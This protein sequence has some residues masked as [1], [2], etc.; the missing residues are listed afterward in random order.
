[1]QAYSKLEKQTNKLYDKPTEYTMKDRGNTVYCKCGHT[2]EFWHSENKELCNWC[3]NYVFKTQKNE[4]EY[5]LNEK[6]KRSNK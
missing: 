4:F 3:G 5:R 1:M 2:V 6:M